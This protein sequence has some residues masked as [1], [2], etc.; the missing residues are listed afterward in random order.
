MIFSKQVNRAAIGAC[1]ALSVLS[2]QSATLHAQ[3]VLR[4]IDSVSVKETDAVM[5]ARIG[6]MTIGP[7]GD[8]FETDGSEGRIIQI[9][10]NGTI[11]RTFGRKG[12]GPGEL[13]A[14]ASVAILDD[15]LFVRGGKRISLFSLKTGKFIRSINVT[16]GSFSQLEFIGNQL[17]GLSVDP[18][19]LAPVSV[20]NPAGETIRTEGVLPALVH[21]NPKLAGASFQMAIAT[22]GD[23]V[24]GANDFTQSL[25]RWKRGTSVAVEEL[26]LPVVRRR[27]VNPDNYVQMLRDPS[28]AAKL[29]YSHSFAT[30]L[31]FISADI[32]GLLTFDPTIDDKGQFS[33]PQHLTLVD[34]KSKRVCADVAVPVLTNPVPQLALKADTLI[35]LEQGSVHGDDVVAYIRRFKIDPKQCTWKSL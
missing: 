6:P 8:I 20:L 1:F 27:G 22:R 14:P 7:R 30:G 34:T 35:T 3:S 16:L 15:T 21:E 11:V 33:G 31:K 12:Q 29:A 24:W 28:L 18:K 10:P 4:K 23:D 17:V 19:T 9:A 5:I 2:A 13:S 32:L 26:K 25:V